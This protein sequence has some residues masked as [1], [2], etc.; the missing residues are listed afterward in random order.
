MIPFHI[1]LSLAHRRSHTRTQQTHLNE[2]LTNENKKK[3]LKVEK[4]V[5]DHLNN[6]KPL[7]VCLNSHWR[8]K[9]TMDG[10]PSYRLCVYAF[11]SNVLCVLNNNTNSVCKR[12]KHFLRLC[13]PNNGTWLEVFDEKEDDDLTSLEKSHT[14]TQTMQK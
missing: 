14:H 2:H 6:I 12:E 7:I 9:S 10:P 8:R 1:S 11:S 13:V 5:L 4:W 3:S